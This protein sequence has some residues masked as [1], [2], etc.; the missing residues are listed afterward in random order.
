MRQGSGTSSPSCSVP[1]SDPTVH[2]SSL[3][4]RDFRNYRSLDIE[5][6]P[7]F[8]L[9]LGDNAQGKTSVLEAIYLLATLRS[10]RGAG[11]ARM[12]REGARGYF[13]GAR[14]QDRQTSE[15]GLY[16]SAEER[17]I[18]RDGRGVG[19]IAD[20]LG[21]LRSVIFS[22]EDLQ[23]VGG[24]AR[25][26]RRFLDLLSVQH[27]SANLS[28]LQRYASTLRSRNALLKRQDASPGV[29][30]GF[31]RELVRA[32]NEIMECRRRLVPG[33]AALAARACTGISGR[34]EELLLSYRPSVREDY[35]AELLAARDRERRRGITLV[36]PHRD[37]LLLRLNGRDATLY[38]SEGQKRSVAIALKMAQAEWLSRL[39][40]TPPVL[41]LDDV[42]GELDLA[43]RSGLV[44]LV[45][46]VCRSSGQVF[47][48]CTEENWQAVSGFVPARWH[49]RDGTIRPLRTDS[50][51]E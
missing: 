47:M 27:R 9:L 8:H 12:V 11:N 23:A 15:L 18:Q 25:I 34:T 10:F 29:L 44:D 3:R 49:V 24:P 40:R 20:Y 42:M 36:G 2:L 50:L 30:D 51:P 37:D 46:S 5:F 4:L 31:D 33:I 21:G 45:G 16:W 32:G 17:R 43:R 7:G 28:L 48:T 35:A 14:V 39:T 38:G 13:A 41:L 1:P 6:G 26:R 22:S 19:S